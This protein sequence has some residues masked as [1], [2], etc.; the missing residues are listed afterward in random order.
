MSYSTVLYNR[1][2]KGV[3]VAH[4]KTSLKNQAHFSLTTMRLDWLGFQID[5]KCFQQVTKKYML[6]GIF[7]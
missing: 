3:S 2:H 1:D 7:Y 6:N 4:E 5:S